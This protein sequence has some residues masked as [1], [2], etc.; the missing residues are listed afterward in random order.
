MRK[1]LVVAGFTVL[2]ALACA[3]RGASA[4]QVLAFGSGSDLANRETG[5]VVLVSPSYSQGWLN[6]TFPGPSGS[7]WV[8]ARYQMVSQA[9]RVNAGLGQAFEH[10]P[11]T[12]CIKV[13]NATLPNEHCEQPQIDGVTIGTAYTIS[14]QVWLPTAPAV[15]TVRFSVPAEAYGMAAIRVAQVMV[16]AA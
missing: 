8:T 12:T 1:R 2:A 14:A 11:V 6:G 9:G 16:T 7:V 13:E 4:D 15:V 10:V 5:A 3:A